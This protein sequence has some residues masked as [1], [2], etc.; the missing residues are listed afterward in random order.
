MLGDGPGERQSRQRSER[1]AS[2]PR[3][4]TTCLRV[5]GEYCRRVPVEAGN[6]RAEPG[7]LRAPFRWN[8]EA[9]ERGPVVDARGDDRVE[10][11]KRDASHGVVCR[12]REHR[13]PAGERGTRPTMELGEHGFPQRRIAPHSHTRRVRAGGQ[14]EAQQRDAPHSRVSTCSSLATTLSI[15]VRNARKSA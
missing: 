2:P 13:S 7:K 6:V 12:V 8:N 14:R 4:G 10:P 11:G 9:T 1:R 3:H 5:V 15:A